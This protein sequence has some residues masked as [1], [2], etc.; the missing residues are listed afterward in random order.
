MIK[1]NNKN[2]GT[3]GIIL[4]FSRLFDFCFIRFYYKK[5][6]SV[7]KY[8][9]FEINFFISLFTLIPIIITLTIYILKSWHVLN[10]I[11]KFIYNY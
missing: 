3:L 7:F 1:L 6:F 2:L 5:I 9:V 8:S 4:G 11:I 10:R